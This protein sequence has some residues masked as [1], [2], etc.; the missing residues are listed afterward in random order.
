MGGRCYM[1]ALLPGTFFARHFLLKDEKWC[2]VAGGSAEII[3]IFLPGTFY[4]IIKSDWVVGKSGSKG[5]FFEKMS[6]TRHLK[7]LCTYQPLY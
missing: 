6:A 3:Y 2:E 1:A 5:H 7:L 4:E